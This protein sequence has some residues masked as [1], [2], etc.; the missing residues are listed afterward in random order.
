MTRFFTLLFFAALF[1][2]CGGSEGTAVEATDAVD[3]NAGVTKEMPSVVY[4]LDAAASTVTWEGSKVVGGGHT[5][6]MQ[7]FG[8]RRA[9]RFRTDHQG[10]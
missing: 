8:A 9:C 6:G 4:N 10:S 5:G 3:A 7:L 1:V 2:A